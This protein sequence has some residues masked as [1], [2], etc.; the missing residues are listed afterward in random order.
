MVGAVNRTEK[1]AGVA[2]AG[3]R[4]TSDT[5]NVAGMAGEWA[6]DASDRNPGAGTDNKS[7]FV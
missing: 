3:C 4:N 7:G 1:R 2:S 6:A 5:A